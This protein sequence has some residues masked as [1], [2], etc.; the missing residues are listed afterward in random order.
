MLDLVVRFDA[1]CYIDHI[2]IVMSMLC[3]KT[4]LFTAVN[5]FTGNVSVV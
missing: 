4:T 3:K 5:V 1:C 2:K